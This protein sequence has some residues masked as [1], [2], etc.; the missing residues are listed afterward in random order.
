[1]TDTTRGLGPGHY[2]VV[3][4]TSDPT[5]GPEST[6]SAPAKGERAGRSVAT[7]GR[8]FATG[9]CSGYLRR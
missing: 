9:R 3:P 1:M 7:P 6:L 5:G 8:S 4:V 2:V